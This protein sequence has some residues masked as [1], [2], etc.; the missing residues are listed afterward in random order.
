MARRQVSALI[1]HRRLK[2][3][4]EGDEVL[5][6]LLGVN[7]VS[8]ND[9]RILRR[10]QELGS[11]HDR[12]GISLRRRI[13]REL[14][15]AQRGVIGNGRLLQGAIDHDDHRLSRRSHGDPVG[16]HSGLREMRQRDG[17]VVP[18]GVLADHGRRILGAV[19]PLHAGAPLG[20]VEGVADH[21][22]DGRPAGP[23]VVDTHRGML[24][25]HGAVGQDEHRLAFDHRVALGQG[26]RGLF[27][28]TGDE[29]GVL[30][31]A[32]VD[33]RL[34][35]AAKTGARIGGHVLEAE[36]FDDVDHEVGAGAIDRQHAD[37]AGR[38]RFPGRHGRDRSLRLYG[39]LSAQ[40]AGA[41][42]QCGHTADSRAF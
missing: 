37:F 22:E 19:I 12:A 4:G 29:L 17:G 14:G 5:H 26:D 20:G 10:D 38:I 39:L 25:A 27:V 31:A 23:G 7:H 8:R 21:D 2:R 1:D 15:Y 42:N 40:C 16:A 6:A 9:H 13:Q 34:V 18:F 41:R 30:V 36:S 11:F 32:V 3:F 28:A 33:Q 24:Q 35:N